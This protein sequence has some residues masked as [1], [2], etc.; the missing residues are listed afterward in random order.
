MHESKHEQYEQYEQKRWR[1]LPPQQGYGQKNQFEMSF[2]FPS[3]IFQDF[4]LKLEIG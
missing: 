4:S 1:I 3:S 2:P